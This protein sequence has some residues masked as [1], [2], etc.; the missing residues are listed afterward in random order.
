MARKSRRLPEGM[1]E[2]EAFEIAALLQTWKEGGSWNDLSKGFREKADLYI[3]KL[4]GLSRRNRYA[5]PGGPRKA[6]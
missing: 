6:A 5:G 4:T 2:E 1:T 3:E